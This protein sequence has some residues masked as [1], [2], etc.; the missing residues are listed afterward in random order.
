MNS[1]KSRKKRYTITVGLKDKNEKEQKIQTE[2]ILRLVNHCC[3]GYGL[4]FSCFL[5]DGGYICDNRDYVMEK[6]VCI[7]FIDPDENL[8]E[9]IGKD[10]CAFMN[11]ESVLVTVDE[12]EFYFISESIR[13]CL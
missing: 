13:E 9:E 11:Q 10:L 4:A 1:A 12:I 7:V 5:Q 2:Q 3:K 8:I 6:S